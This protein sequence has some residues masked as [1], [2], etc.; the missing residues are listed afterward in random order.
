MSRTIKRP[1]RKG[2]RLGSDLKFCSCWYC[3]Y[4]R[5]HFGNPYLIKTLRRTYRHRVKI[6]LRC[7]RYEEVENSISIPYTD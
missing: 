2:K 1:V 6:A 4:G 5:N 7:G 3:K